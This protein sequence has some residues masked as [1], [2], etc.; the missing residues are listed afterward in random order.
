MQ[1]TVNAKTTNNLAKNIEPSEACTCAKITKVGGYS[2][3]STLSLTTIFTIN[4]NE[5]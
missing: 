3:F 4:H 1:L 2:Y 5:K